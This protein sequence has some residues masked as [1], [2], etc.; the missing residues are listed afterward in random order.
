VKQGKELGYLSAVVFVLDGV[1]KIGA[2]SLPVI[3]AIREQDVELHRLADHR[4]TSVGNEMIDLILFVVSK[5][6]LV[7]L[8]GCAVE[9]FQTLRM[10]HRNG[11]RDQIPY[12]NGVCDM[13][14]DRIWTEE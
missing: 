2:P 3:A 1:K 14:N 9:R 5:S 12:G 6:R 11:T 10:K 8:C 13:R 4:I 7:S